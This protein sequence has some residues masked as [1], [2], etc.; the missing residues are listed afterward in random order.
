MKAEAL[1]IKNSISMN[2]FDKIKNQISM[3]I[4]AALKPYIEIN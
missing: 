3:Y 4:P 2:Q 1:L